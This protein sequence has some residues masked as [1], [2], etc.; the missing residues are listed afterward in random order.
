MV[1][2]DARQVTPDVALVPARANLGDAH[3]AS[4][5]APDDALT[6]SW[7][8]LFSDKY[9]GRIAWRDDAHGMVFNAGVQV[10][11]RV[12]SHAG[13]GGFVRYSR[14]NLTFPDTAAAAIKLGGVELGGGL[15]LTF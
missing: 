7:N 6:Q 2:C 9:R 4:K 11:V 13:V 5:I 12:V 3:D 1:H 14:A 15:H 10:G 8:V